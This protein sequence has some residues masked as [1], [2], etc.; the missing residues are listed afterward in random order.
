MYELRLRIYDKAAFSCRRSTLIFSVKTG[1]VIKIDA[2]RQFD[3]VTCCAI[4]NER[5]AS[6]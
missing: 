6:A 4:E 1:H 2:I 3:H 5:R